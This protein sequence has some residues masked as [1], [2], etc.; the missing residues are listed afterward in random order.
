M[1]RNS[2]SDPDKIARILTRTAHFLIAAHAYPIKTA[3]T[4]QK[5]VAHEQ[6]P[7]IRWH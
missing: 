3:G 6:R 4:F 5:V 7:G 1:K 2:S